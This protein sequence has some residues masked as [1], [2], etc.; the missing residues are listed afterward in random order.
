MKKPRNLNH[1]VPVTSRT[2]ASF[3]VHLLL[4]TRKSIGNIRITATLA[5]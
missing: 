5:E 2:S 4:H 1:T 3:R